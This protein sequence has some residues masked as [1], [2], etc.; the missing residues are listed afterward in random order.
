MP[1]RMRRPGR[2][3]HA[4]TSWKKESIEMEEYY[5]IRDMFVPFNPSDFCR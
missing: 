4:G 2:L 3:R 5:E 1:W